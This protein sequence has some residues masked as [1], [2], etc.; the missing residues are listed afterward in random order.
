MPLMLYVKSYLTLGITLNLKVGLPLEDTK[1]TFGVV[2][3]AHC[4]SV[5]FHPQ[6]DN[7]YLQIF[8]GQNLLKMVIVDVGVWGD[9]LNPHKF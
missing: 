3:W 5:R 4:G 8:R 6:Y 7:W 1:V 2:W 9:S